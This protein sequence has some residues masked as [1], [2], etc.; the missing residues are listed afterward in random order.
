MS[1]VLPA[2]HVGG[3]PVTV[4]TVG[5]W[6]PMSLGTVGRDADLA[7][8]DALPLIRGVAATVCL[9]LSWLLRHFALSF[10]SA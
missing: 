5:S 3:P 1:L 6:R 9:L 10:V 7:L 2:A 4:V 8:F